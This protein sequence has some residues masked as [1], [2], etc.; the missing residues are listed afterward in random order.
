[1]EKKNVKVLM[2]DD[3]KFLLGMY[4]LKFAQSGYDVDTALG[5]GAA[6]NK[7]R[8]GARPDI[9]ILDIVM[10]DMTGLQLLQVVRDEK[11]A[12]DATVIMLTNQNDAASIE[13]AK[14]LGADGYIIKA[15]TIPSEV[16]HVVERIHAIR[17][18]GK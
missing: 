16:I 9:L 3:D 6:L 14:E 8:T 17:R 5:S 18:G 10:P 1:M 4:S 7:L 13:R 2:V 12:Q 15:S 11:L